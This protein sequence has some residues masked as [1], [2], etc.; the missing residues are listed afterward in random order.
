LPIDDFPLPIELRMQHRS[1]FSQSTI[2]NQKSTFR[3]QRLLVASSQL[4][5]AI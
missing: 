2:D 4:P 5:V 1:V 3:S